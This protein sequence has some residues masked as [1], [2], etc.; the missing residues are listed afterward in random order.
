LQ[1]ED[2][3]LSR[4]FGDQFVD[5]YRFVL[6]DAVGAVGGLCLDRRVPPWVIVDNGIG[7][8]EVE[9][10]AAGLEGDE[11]EVGLTAAEALDRVFAFACLSGQLGVGDAGSL[12]LLLDQAEHG[13]ELGEDQDVPSRRAPESPPRWVWAGLDGST[14]TV[15]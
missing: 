10:D 1:G 8:D 3:L 2:F 13:G 4:A 7:L 15:G 6:A 11:E 14:P 12:Y 5:E 9:A